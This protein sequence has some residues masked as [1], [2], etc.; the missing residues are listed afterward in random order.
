MLTSS[1]YQANQPMHL[2]KTSAGIGVPNV[3]AQPL[4]CGFFVPIA[5]H[6]FLVGWVEQSKDWPG[7]TSVRQLCSVRL[8]MIGV[9]WRRVYNLFSKVAIMF[10]IH[11][12][13]PLTQETLTTSVNSK[14]QSRFN[15]LT[16]S[17]LSIAR[18]VPFST[19]IQLKNGQPDLTIKFSGMEV[20]L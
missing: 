2:Q 15:V 10:K 4:I 1:N 13:K 19:A 5:Q 18:R 20:S 9:V 8:P 3:A 11:K 14:S 17:G 6:S 12:T 7:A 16:K